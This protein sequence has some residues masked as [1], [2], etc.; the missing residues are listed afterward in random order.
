MEAASTGKTKM[1]TRMGTITVSGGTGTRGGREG[2]TENKMFTVTLSPTLCVGILV[3]LPPSKTAVPA[4]QS[5]SRHHLPRINKVV[6]IKK[7]P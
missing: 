4:V 2:E 7:T 6:S 3:P 5:N 1:D